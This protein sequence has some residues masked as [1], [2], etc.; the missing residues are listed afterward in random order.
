VENA[1]LIQQ[2]GRRTDKMKVG[3]WK[4]AG[5]SDDPWNDLAD[6]LAVRGRNQSKANV[7]VQV[8]FRPFVD[9]EEMFWA[10]PRLSLNPNANIYDFWP[11]LVDKWGRHGDPEDYVIW[12]DRA[13]LRGPLF[14]GLGYEIVPRS[15][16]G[17]SNRQE[18]ETQLISQFMPWM[19]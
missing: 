17:E 7:T 15:L 18:G 6:S 9:G 12:N 10:I 11:H 13:P 3:F 5:H 2:V 1:A 19:A 16:Q 14:E 8:L 4:I